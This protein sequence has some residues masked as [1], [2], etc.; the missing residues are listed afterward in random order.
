MLGSIIGFIIL[1][2]LL[3]VAY[4]YKYGFPIIDWMLILAYLIPSSILFCIHLFL[5]R[6]DMAKADDVKSSLSI[7]EINLNK[8]Y[9]AEIDKAKDLS[10]NIQ[11][12][13][14]DMDD[15][16]QKMMTD[17]DKRLKDMN[18]SLIDKINKKM[19]AIDNN[20][21][22]KLDTT[23]ANSRLNDLIS[24]T[25]ESNQNLKTIFDFNDNVIANKLNQL[26]TL[27]ANSMTTA[28]EKMELSK[29]ARQELVDEL[30]GLKM[31]LSQSRG[32]EWKKA[33]EEYN[34]LKAKLSEMQ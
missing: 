15:A 17:I 24:K 34:K 32:E 22:K 3:L 2:I 29:K 18:D 26:E 5:V 21:N 1:V 20:L 31:K 27:W 16:K 11:K 4:F 30:N 9:N 10:Q 33:F 13:I 12:S 7:A 25:D 8:N 6:H 14:R 23:I 28:I 19:D